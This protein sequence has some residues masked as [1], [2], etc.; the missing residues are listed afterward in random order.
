[1]KK[2]NTTGPCIPSKHYMVDLS[3]RVIEIG[4]LVD[5][6]K[7][8][9]I[10][11]ARQYG[12]TTT[13]SALAAY[14]KP[15]YCVL[16]LDFQRIGSAGFRTEESFVKAFSRLLIRKADKVGMPEQIIQ[17]FE[18]YVSRKEG[19]AALDELFMT[20]SDWCAASEKP[21]IMII[22]EVD[23][24]TNN[25]VFLDFLAQLRLAY[26]ER[27]E[28]PEEKTFQSVIL[29]GVTDVKHLKSKIRD[30]DQHKVNSPWNIAADFDI[31]MSLSECGIKGMLEEYEADHRTGM[32]TA[33]IAKQI[34]EYTNGYPFLVSRI[35]QLIDEKFVPEKF[36]TLS[37]AWT[38]YGV[39]EAVKAILSED[40][41][42][43]GSLM[44]K[45]INYPETHEKGSPWF[46]VYEKGKN[47]PI[48]Q[49]MMKT[50]Y[51]GKTL[52]T[53]DP[54]QLDI[55]VITAIPLA[56]D[57]PEDAAYD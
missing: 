32:D 6:G 55:P 48:P 45:L 41:T 31:K 20:L 28:D 22:D 1:M 24:A 37:G 47:R 4:K 13:I 49:D 54:S 36:G 7:Y 33:A 21:M 9:T 25:Q 16:S 17:G 46:Q 56:W 30:E 5:E 27:E 52:D 43:F 44:G 10:N 40:N 26:I 35:C 38:E 11:R 8:F 50:Y 34:R 18:D 57:S 53:F 2:F 51:S 14:L 42:L 29:A 19:E 3:E 15:E 12:K 39:D 23:S